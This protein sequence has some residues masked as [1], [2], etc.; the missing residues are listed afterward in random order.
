[1]KMHKKL[2]SCIT[3]F[4]VA[5]IFVF[6]LPTKANA[7]TGNTGD[8][9]WVLEGTTLTISGNGRMGDYDHSNKPWGSDITQVIIEEGVTYIGQWAFY[10]C[11]LESVSIAS[12]VTSIGDSAFQSARLTS[13]TIPE[14]VTGVGEGAFAECKSLVEVKFPSTLQFIGRWAFQSCPMKSIV[15]PSSIKTIRQYAF[16]F[17]QIENVWYLGSE[18]DKASLSIGGDNLCLNTA[19]W[20]YN[21]CPIGAPH[22]YNG[23]CDNSCNGCGEIR[24]VPDHSYDSECDNCCN[25]CGE[26]RTVPNHIYDNACDADCNICGGPR[27]VSHQH[28]AEW[29]MTKTNHWYECSICGDKKDLGA[30]TPGVAA[31][32]STA[33]TCTTCGFVVTPALGH[34]HKYSDN[35]SYNP[36]G[37]WY[38][39][40]GCS[41]QKDYTIHVYNNA[42]DTDCND[43]GHVRAIAH[44]F[45][46]TWTKDGANH[47]RVCTVCGETAELASHSWGSGFCTVCGESDPSVTLPTDPTPTDIPTVPAPTDAPTEPTVEPTVPAPTDMPTEPT[48]TVEPTTEPTTSATAPANPAGSDQPNDDLLTWI[49]LACILLGGVGIVLFIFLKIK[50]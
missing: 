38:A 28:G 4:A 49:I 9:T 44:S 35:L 41:E 11:N 19:T 16:N 1:M 43:C 37:H 3:A 31:T 27:N 50:R 20:H 45:A 6:V 33:Q 30:H 25:G 42:C 46:A 10:R 14:G 22:A 7:A 36:E 47:W 12:T 2:L 26:L 29:V 17:C 32:E 21:S 39:C 8:C 23:I 13:I 18:S 5:M 48:G 34:T 24:E 40:S 15:L